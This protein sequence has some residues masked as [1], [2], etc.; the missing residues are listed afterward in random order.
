M[1]SVVHAANNVIRL[2]TILIIAPFKLLRISYGMT[3]SGSMKQKTREV[4]STR[5][6]GTSSHAELK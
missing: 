4:G 2:K 5:K 3:G 1:A 6:S